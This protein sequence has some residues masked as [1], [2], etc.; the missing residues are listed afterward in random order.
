MKIT[1]YRTLELNTE[2]ELPE[3]KD[4]ETFLVDFMAG[5]KNADFETVVEESVETEDGKTIIVS[6]RFKRL[7]KFRV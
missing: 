6:S 1:C 7:Q 2:I 3:G 5:I 4:V